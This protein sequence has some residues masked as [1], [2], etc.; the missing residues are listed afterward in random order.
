MV[1]YREMHE[2]TAKGFKSTNRT[3]SN[4]P[5]LDDFGERQLPLAG[6]PPL[7]I[8]ESLTVGNYHEFYQL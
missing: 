7:W 6:F 3:N 5:S 8:T 1:T 4:F 2:Y